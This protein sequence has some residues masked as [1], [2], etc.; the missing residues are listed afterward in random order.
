MNTL[1]KVVIAI[2]V[3]LLV[4]LLLWGLW[5]MYEDKESMTE[6][7]RGRRG[8]G[9]RGRRRRW[10]WRR[11]GRRWYNWYYP[12]Y[13]VVDVPDPLGVCT[14]QCNSQFNP[15]TNANVNERAKCIQACYQAKQLY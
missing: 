14:R 8:R 4:L 1:W 15:P 2:V 11:G 10:G 13:Y 3:I 9:R 12:Q 5:Y 6:G 7:A